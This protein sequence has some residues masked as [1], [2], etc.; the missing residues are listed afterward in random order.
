MMFFLLY[1]VKNS[2]TLT[3]TYMF[4]INNI[5][6]TKVIDK[7]YISQKNNNKNNKKKNF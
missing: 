1:T 5:A 3:H 6:E 7:F 2:M 4:K